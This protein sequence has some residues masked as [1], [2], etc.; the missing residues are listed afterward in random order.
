LNLTFQEAARK[1]ARDEITSLSESEAGRRFLLL[2]SLSRREY[3]EK[4]VADYNL[5]LS[6]SKPRELFP[7]IYASS[8]S[9]EKIKGAIKS[10]F[11]VERAVRAATEG[12]LINELY[13]M[14]EFYWGGLHQNSLEKTIVDNYV[15]RIRNFEELNKK[16]DKEIY[17]SMRGYVRCTWYNHWTAIIIEDIFKEHKNVLPAVGLI[18]KVDFFI[19]DVPFDLKVTPL[20]EGYIKEQRKTAG[21]K[22]ELTLLKQACR[23]RHLKIDQDFSESELL[24]HLWSVVAD[25]PDKDAKDLIEDLRKFRLH[26][27]AEIEDAPQNLIRWLYENQGVRRFDASNRLFLV[28]VNETNFF[29]SWQLKRNKAL[30]VKGIGEYLDKA[31][32]HPGI[33]V[34]FAWEDATYTTRSAV[35]LIRHRG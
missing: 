22:P 5:L 16:I 35:I 12:E 28:L 10:I 34:T 24:G 20:P 8:L 17:E 27:T 15:K 18:K 2:R 30:L 33:D 32:P 31:G 4:L 9:V 1:Y 25:Q 6:S 14:K 29:E 21:R 19:R 23:H 11:S 7:A 26:L 13:K 3:L